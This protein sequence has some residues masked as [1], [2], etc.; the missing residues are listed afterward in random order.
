MFEEYNSIMNV[1]EV[2]EA[3]SA[4]RNYIYS[5]LKQRNLHGFR[6]GREWRIAKEELI[7]YVCRRSG[8]ERR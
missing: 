8:L 2:C 3:L 4:G 7:Q 5:E 6:I 1:E